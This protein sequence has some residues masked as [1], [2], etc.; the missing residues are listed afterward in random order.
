MLNFYQRHHAKM[1]RLTVLADNLCV[2][3]PFLQGDGIK[4]RRFLSCGK[5]APRQLS[6]IPT[7]QFAEGSVGRSR[8]SSVDDRRAA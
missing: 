1:R 5:P 3:L 8:A 6:V 4:L 7:G 2:I